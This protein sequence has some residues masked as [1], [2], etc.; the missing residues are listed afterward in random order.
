MRRPFRPLTVAIA[1]TAVA[2]VALPGSAVQ[3][4]PPA[5][6]PTI[7]WTPCAED[8]TAECGTLR[9]PVDW[10]RP[11]GQ[12]FELALARRKATDPAARIGSLVINPGGPGGSGVDFALFAHEYFTPDIARRFDIVGFDPRGVARS[13]PVVCSLDLL[14]QAPSPLLTSQAD[15]DAMLAFNRRLR[16]D[17]RRHTGPLYD[18]VDTSSVVRDLDALRAALGD[19]KLSYYGVSY[20]TLI[21]QQYAEVFP[22][23][24]R[25]LTLDSNMDHSLGTRDFMDTETLSVQDAFEEFA[26]WCDRTVGCAL[27]GRDVSALWRDLLAR[28]DRGEVHDPGEP[29]I[30]LTAFDIINF[31]TGAFYGPAWFE[32]AELIAALDAGS[33]L[34]A[35]V[36][37]RLSPPRAQSPELVENPFEAV[38]CQDWSLPVRDY[39][40]FARHLRRIGRLAPDMRYSPLA[41][42]VTSCLGTPTPINNPQHRLDVR[43]SRTLLLTNSLHDPATGYNWAA[44]AARQLG[45]SAVL[46]T[47]EGW[48]H[49]VYAREACST[50]VVDRYLIGL[51]LPPRGARCPGV[52]PTPPAIQLRQSVLPRTDRWRLLSLPHM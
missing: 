10:S 17:C 31:A 44:N 50:G 16:Q 32:L 33:A 40:E 26:A 27:H 12:T 52:E 2:A 46:L 18:H 25:A 6:P 13:H 49:G 23:R 48:G 11:R 14:L 37:A 45:R 7:T 38:F 36:R 9:V 41:L 35:T 3:A 39:A 30:V 43:G 22:H 4:A 21:G 1:V 47:Y 15:F 42:I 28:A 34:S 24:V 19:D 20:G 51:R 29:T 8:P 5:R